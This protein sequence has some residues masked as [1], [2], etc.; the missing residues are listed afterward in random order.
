MSWVPR[1]SSVRPVGLSR[2]SDQSGSS[3]SE[4]KFSIPHIILGCPLI[5]GSPGQL[6]S[7]TWERS[8]T[9]TGSAGSSP[10]QKWSLHQE[11]SSTVQAAHP[12]Y[13]GIHVPCPSLA[14]ISGNCRYLNPSVFTFLTVNLGTF[15]TCKFT[16]IWEC[17]SLLTTSDLREIWLKVT[18]SGDPLSYAAWQI[19]TLAERWLGSTC[20]TL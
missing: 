5:H 19:S 6:I 13:G 2:K 10:K 18:W 14:P 12:S 16:M 4:C 11:S 7:I 3:G 1:C 9:E 20:L 15:V 8:G 17:K